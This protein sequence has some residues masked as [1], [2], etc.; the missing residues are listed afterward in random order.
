VNELAKN[1]G[2]HSY[3]IMCFDSGKMP[4]QVQ[5]TVKRRLMWLRQITHHQKLR[6]PL[7]HVS[8]AGYVVC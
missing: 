1:D 8:I 2:F 3:L 7:S 6:I 5:V 4:R